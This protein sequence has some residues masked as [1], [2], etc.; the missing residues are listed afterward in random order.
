M[1]RTKNSV[2]PASADLSPDPSEFDSPLDQVARHAWPWIGPIPQEICTNT[3]DAHGGIFQFCFVSAKGAEIKTDH[4]TL[5]LRL[6]PGKN[7]DKPRFDF[8]KSA[9]IEKYRF[10]I[11][12][13]G[14]LSLQ[15]NI[16][17]ALCGLRVFVVK[18]LF[19]EPQVLSKFIKKARESAKVHVSTFFRAAVPPKN[20]FPC[21]RNTETPPLANEPFT[22]IFTETNR[23]C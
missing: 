9:I 13:T 2:S 8:R 4:P 16:F 10:S 3:S 19:L 7:V 18:S 15:K 5:H 12:P 1:M 17:S 22:Q 21:F 23:I 14:H 20:K 11:V 6:I